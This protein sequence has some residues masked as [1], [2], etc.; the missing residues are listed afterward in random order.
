MAVVPW[1][2]SLGVIAVPFTI[3]RAEQRTAYAEAPTMTFVS[4]APEAAKL[5]FAGIG[6]DLMVRFDDGEWQPATVQATAEQTV[7]EH[8]AS[9]WVDVPA[10]TTE[11][12]FQGQA[13][14]GGP[15]HVRDATFWSL[16][17]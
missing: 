4:P 12:Q 7:E 6:L 11:V 3:V 10:G 14:Y 13:W 17:S 5:R 16:D 1:P 2:I 8:F 9:Y 15:W